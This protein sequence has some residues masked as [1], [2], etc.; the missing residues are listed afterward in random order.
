MKNKMAYIALSALAFTSVYASE[1]VTL[2][3]AERMVDSGQ[4]I[5]VK[6]PKNVNIAQVTTD[7]VNQTKVVDVNVTAS[8]TSVPEIVKVVE[9]PKTIDIVEKVEFEKEIE[10]ISIAMPT[11]LSSLLN[12]LSQATGETYFCDDEIN[13]PAARIKIKSIDHLNKY[14]KQVTGF[15][16]EIVRE[17]N[18]PAI[19]K[20]LRVVK[21]DKAN[22]K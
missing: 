9:I 20:V 1:K 4:A 7:D 10:G 8:T 11:T 3:E 2:N 16:I 14:L 17:S 21:T 13:I 6:L 22:K 19:P 15:S 18:D 5:L 12:K